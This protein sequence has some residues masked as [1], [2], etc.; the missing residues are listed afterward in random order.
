MFFKV[1]VVDSFYF[2]VI[3]KIQ[4]MI[5]WKVPLYLSRLGS[6]LQ[7][8]KNILSDFAPFQQPVLFKADQ[9]KVVSLL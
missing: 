7:D 3:Y 8:Y 9:L 1:Y 5:Y 6:L 4:S 2:S